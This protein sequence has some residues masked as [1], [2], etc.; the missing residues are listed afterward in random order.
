[1]DEFEWH[2][3]RLL[4]ACNCRYSSYWNGDEDDDDDNDDDVIFIALVTGLP[5]SCLFLWLLLVVTYKFQE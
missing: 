1:M 5:F 3:V 2:I 4:S